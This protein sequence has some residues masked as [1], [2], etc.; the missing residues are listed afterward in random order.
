MASIPLPALSV[1]PPQQQ[2]PI[3]GY[4]DLMALKS[5]QQQQQIQQ[6]QAQGEQQRNESQAIQLQQTKTQLQLAPQFLQKDENGKV[7][8]FDQEGYFGAAMGSGA[9]TPA[10]VAAMKAQYADATKKIADAGSAQ[11]EFQDKKNNQA[12]QVLEG[13]KSVAAKGDPNATQQAYVNGLTQ[14]RTLGAD[15]SKYP[16][17]YP[18]D[19]V[20]NQIEVGLGMHKQM[21]SDAKDLASTQESGAR[22][23]EAAANT[24]KTQVET[25]L[26]KQYGN[27]SQQEARYLHLEQVK[28][29][30]GALPPQDAAFVKAY[31]H[32]KTLVPTA[33]FN[34]QNAGMTGTGGQPSAIA[35]AVANGQMKW[36]DVISPRTPQTVKEALLKEIKQINPNFNSGDFSIE[37]RVKE[38]FTSGAAA[39]NL[40]A[41]N[42]A[43]EHAK[44]LQGAADAL[45]NGDAVALNKLGN[46]LGY[47]FGSD[48]MTNFNVIKNA[49]TG[50]ISKVFKGG[51]ATDA[52]I[53]AVQDP[54]NAANSPAQLKGAIENAVKLMNSKRDALKQQYQSGVQA[55]PNFGAEN[56][57]PKSDFFSNFGGQSRQ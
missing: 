5:L 14:L 54:F 10:Q 19:S 25:E 3:Q 48:K 28:A 38:E 52:E 2:N 56:G 37:Q 21:I 8:G 13:V 11:I 16:P 17:T 53:K 40:T 50:E 39:Q 1:Q 46:Q 27:P 33:T 30:G 29:M 36:G 35:Q 23:Q 51:Q 12:Y 9:M 41:F 22:A 44:Q 47:Q 4:R 32:F 24:A 18:G 42:T 55:K 7:T 20:L 45:Q 49:L 43:I 6:L 31:E 15:I 26:L 34:M 57:Q